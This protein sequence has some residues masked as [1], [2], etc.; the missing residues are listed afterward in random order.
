MS[1]GMKRAT[2]EQLLAEVSDA[3]LLLYIRKGSASLTLDSRFGASYWEK[4]DSLRREAKR[5][6][7]L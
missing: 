4:D 6:N 5:R 1:D 2:V 3:D 7:L